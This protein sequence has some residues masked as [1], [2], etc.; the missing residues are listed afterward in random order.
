MKRPLDCWEVAILH[1]NATDL[2]PRLRVRPDYPA[3]GALRVEWLGIPLDLPL[4]QELSRGLA[5]IQKGERGFDRVT[6][7]FFIARRE[8]IQPYFLAVFERDLGLD[9]IRV[10]AGVAVGCFLGLNHKL[11]C[12]AQIYFDRLTGHALAPDARAIFLDASDVHR[13]NDT[14]APAARLFVAVDADPGGKN[15]PRGGQPDGNSARGVA[16]E[17]PRE[18]LSPNPQWFAGPGVFEHRAVIHVHD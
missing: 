2:E 14:A 8:V 13:K 5:R 16:Q 9:P 15:V 12:A 6:L 18:I 10:V 7:A 3:L 17:S 1:C 4:T 11:G